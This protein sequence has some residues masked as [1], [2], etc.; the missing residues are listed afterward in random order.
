MNIQIILKLINKK[1]QNNIE[2]N[3]KNK[4][5]KNEYLNLK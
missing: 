3:G 1:T 5:R 2:K 4:E